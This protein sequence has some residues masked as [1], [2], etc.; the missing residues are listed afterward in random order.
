MTIGIAEH[1]HLIPMAVIGGLYLRT[2]NAIIASILAKPAHHIQAA[3]VVAQ[4]LIAS[5]FLVI[6]IVHA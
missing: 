3:I 6:I 1:V 4:V 2:M 5:L